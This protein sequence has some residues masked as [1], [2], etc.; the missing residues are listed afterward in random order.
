MKNVTMKRD[1]CQITVPDNLVPNFE[2]TGW[3]KAEPMAA[4][5]E[6]DQQPTGKAQKAAKQRSMS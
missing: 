5:S 3:K 2:K 1:T 6:P 4:A